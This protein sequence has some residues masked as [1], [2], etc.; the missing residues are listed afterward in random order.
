MKKQIRNLLLIILFPILIL[1]FAS[2]SPE[3]VEKYGHIDIF[4]FADNPRSLNLTFFS[5][6]SILIIF[7][8]MSIKDKK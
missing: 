2:F 6:F 1:K 8:L 7:V 5:V 4:N 3:F